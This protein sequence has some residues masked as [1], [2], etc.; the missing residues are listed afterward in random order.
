MMTAENDTHSLLSSQEDPSN[1]NQQVDDNQITVAIDNQSIFAAKKKCKRKGKFKWLS[2]KINR[3]RNRRRIFLVRRH[4][5]HFE[6]GQKRKKKSA[7]LSAACLNRN[8][9][10]A[11]FYTYSASGQSSNLQST[12]KLRIYRLSPVTTNQIS[13]S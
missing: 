2:P 8:L 5:K 12:D 1:S 4:I 11:S 13:H 9:Q 6:H 7:N 3:P 10:F